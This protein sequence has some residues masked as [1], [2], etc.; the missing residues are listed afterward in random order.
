MCVWFGHTNLPG[1]SHNAVIRTAL[2]KETCTCAIWIVASFKCCSSVRFLRHLAFSKIVL[3]LAP[4]VFSDMFR[5]APPAQS[6]RSTR[7]TAQ[8]HTR[9]LVDCCDGS[10]KRVFSRSLFGKVRVYN[11]LPQHCV[12]SSTVSAFQSELTER[13]RASY[14]VALPQW[15]CSYKVVECSHNIFSVSVWSSPSFFCAN[16]EPG[17]VAFQWSSSVDICS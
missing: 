16:C 17:R 5:A 10:H 9:Q 15:Q 11:H 4:A 12:D 1:T 13:A 7:R 6:A 8:S 3:G 2:F 14:R